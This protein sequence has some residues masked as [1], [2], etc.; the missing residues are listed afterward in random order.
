MDP[1]P[2]RQTKD[3]KQLDVVLTL[4]KLAAWLLDATH[5][6]EEIHSIFSD[7]GSLNGSKETA[8]RDLKK[9]AIPL[10]KHASDTVHNKAVTVAPLA[11]TI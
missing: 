6:L 8:Q 5:I 3:D 1:P 9:N 7:E 10:L 4:Y 11:S 2:Q